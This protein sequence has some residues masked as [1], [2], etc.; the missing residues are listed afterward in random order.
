MMWFAQ[1]VLWGW[2]PV[3]LILFLVMPPRRAVVVALIASWLLLPQLRFQ[4]D[5]VPDYTKMTATCYAIIIGAFL[6]DPKQRILA[7]KPMW[8]D[9]P[10]LLYCLHPVRAVGAQRLR[11][12]RRGGG[13]PRTLGGDRAAVPHRP[14]V[15]SNPRAGQG[16]LPGHHHRGAG[17]RAAGAVRAPDESAAAQHV[18]R[19]LAV[20]RL[21]T[22]AAVGRVSAAGV[23]E[24]RSGD[25]A[26]DEHLR[27][28][29]DLA[30]ALQVDQEG[31]A[32]CRCRGW[33]PCCWSRR[34]SANPP[35]RSCCWR[36]CCWR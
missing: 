30:V 1:A 28:P 35:G 25:G 18:L 22:G 5:K 24:S 33:W 27:G 17:L 10:V 31:L 12:V 23:H 21:E 14:T 9:L 34:C 4:I 32:R 15:F 3:V 2:L 8:L 20:H 16:L 6:L 29:G 7:F 13:V 11:P 26:V 19:V 36:W